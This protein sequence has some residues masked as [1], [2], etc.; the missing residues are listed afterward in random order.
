MFYARVIR[1]LAL[2]VFVVLL[3][4]AVPSLTLADTV[5]PDAQALALMQQLNQRLE[6]QGLNVRVGQME[7]FTIGQGRPIYRLLQNPMRF[8][9]NDARRHA[10][11]DRIRYLVDSTADSPVR[12]DTTSGL[13]HV[14]TE[15]AIDAAM[16]TWQAQPCLQHVTIEKRSVPDGVDPDLIDHFYGIGGSWDRLDLFQADIIHAG[17]LPAF[18]PFSYSTLAITF[19]FYFTSNGQP[20]DIN[21]DGY[22][23]TAFT[24]TYY[25][26]NFSWA[27]NASLPAIDVQSVALHESGHAL[28]LGH[29]GP[30]PDAVMNPFYRGIRQSPFPTDD[31]GLCVIWSLWPN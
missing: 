28:G 1:V 15:A 4:S 20:T 13:S 21:R 22:F 25:N 9:P 5:D 3:F 12:G 18:G 24:E 6:A 7:L 17:W 11:G 26:D 19:T 14:Q 2:F 27:L 8:V 16:N 31:A 30:P 23:D 10:D 29:F